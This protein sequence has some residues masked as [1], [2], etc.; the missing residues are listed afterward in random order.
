[1]RKNGKNLV[2]FSSE[3]IELNTELKKFLFKHLYRYYHVER[4]AEKADRVLTDLF[5][6]YV[7]N[8]K[9][10]PPEIMAGYKKSE[11]LERIVCDYIAGM[12]DRFALEEHAKLFDPHSRV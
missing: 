1:V 10:L 12:T 4:M 8:P 2:G 3:V 11:S 5:K 7:H 6:T 9:I